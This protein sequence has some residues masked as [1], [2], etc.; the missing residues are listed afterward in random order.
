MDSLKPKPEELEHLSIESLGPAAIPSPLLKN[1]DHFKNDTAKVLVFSEMQRLGE[2]QKSG[3]KLPA[4][5]IA[6]PQA[7]IFFDPKKIACGIVTCG[8]LCPGLNDVIRTVA[9]SLL[10][11]YGVKKVLGFRYGYN[12][13]SKD[14]FMPPLEITPKVVDEIQHEGGTILGSSRGP[15]EPSEMVDTL[16][17]NKINILFAIGGDGTFRGAHTICEEIKRRKVPLAVIGIPKTIDNDI[18]GSSQTFGFHTAVGKAREAI[19]AAHE[20]A[21]AA[22]NGIGLVKLMGRDSGFIAAHATLAN[23]DVN[24]CF[25]PE[26][27]FSLEGEDGF[28]RLLE[29]RLERK[30]HAVIVVSEG[31]GQD[32]IQKK[33]APKHDESGNIRY[34]DIGLF[35]K[36]HIESHFREKK[37]PLTLKYIDPSYMIRSCPANAEDSA[38][39]LMLG[40]NAV[41]AGMSGKTD[42]FVGFWNQHFTHV[43]FSLGILKKKKLDPSSDLWQ[44]LLETTGQQGRCCL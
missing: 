6:G 22:W 25:V 44:T 30:H 38:F 32:L 14:P 2:Y 43:P 3:K 36:E 8:G 4:F 37:T 12:G 26:V 9:L 27:P 18:Y 11:Q 16:E 1:K 42:I 39:C 24:F 31:A 28:L 13:L 7:K 5:E 40:Q 41:H 17:K 10:W 15:V 23:S 19:Y 20:E 29:K 21:K 33:E 35:L 34:K